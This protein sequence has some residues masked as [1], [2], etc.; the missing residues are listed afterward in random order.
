MSRSVKTLMTLLHQ[1]TSLQLFCNSWFIADSSA[2]VVCGRC[3][4]HCLTLF[5]YW[6]TCDRPSCQEV[7]LSP[8]TI[9]NFGF[10]LCEVITIASER[11]SKVIVRE[12]PSLEDSLKLQGHMVDEL[13]G[14]RGSISTQ[15]PCIISAVSCIQAVI[16]CQV[17]LKAHS[18]GL[19]RKYR[20][21]EFFYNIR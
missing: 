8:L 11:T 14:E 4:Q 15:I 7:L 13:N 1:A 19:S 10:R 9:D 12:K 17:L 3:Q 18:G 20:D 2:P 16:Q 6:E 21:L 5:E